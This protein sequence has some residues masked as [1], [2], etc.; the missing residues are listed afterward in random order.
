MKHE[1]FIKNT[2]YGSWLTMKGFERWRVATYRG[3]D[4]F[5]LY[6]KE[7]IC[8]YAIEVMDRILGRGFDIITEIKGLPNP[9]YEICKENK[10]VL[11]LLNPED[12]KHKG[13][14]IA[15]FIDSFKRKPKKRLS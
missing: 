13:V 8:G 9:K 14:L 10:T 7:G 2:N 11:I 5:I 15:Q 6:N 4:I 3:K 1:R 12:Y